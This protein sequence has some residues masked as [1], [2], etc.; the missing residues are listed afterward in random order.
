MAIAT[1]GLF[2]LEEQKGSSVETARTVAVNVLVACETTYL[3]SARFL[4]VSSGVLAEAFR[5]PSR[6]GWHRPRDGQ[7]L[8]TYAP[9]MQG[10]FGKAGLDLDVWPPIVAAGVALFVAV[11]IEKAVVRWAERNL[12]RSVSGRGWG[13]PAAVGALA[14][15][16]VGS[17]WLYASM[18]RGGHFIRTVEQGAV[19]R[20]GGASGIADLAVVRID[21]EVVGEV[22]VGDTAEFTVGAFP[23][24]GR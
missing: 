21:A 24:P 7:V 10:L 20:V 14:L 17:G 5:Q 23:D 12:A 9:R 19:V 8:F 22:R 15:L 2:D 3:F 13:E 11:E 4:S 18:Q 16:A 1:L 6:F